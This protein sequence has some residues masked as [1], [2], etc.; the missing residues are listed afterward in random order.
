MKKIY[1]VSTGSYS[2]Y[3]VVALFTTVELAEEFMDAVPHSDYNAVEE[4][5]L[6]PDTPDLVKRGYSLWK[7]Q[8]LRNGDTEEAISLGTSIHYMNDVGH[9]VWRRT[10]VPTYKKNGV[11]D[12]LVSTVWAKDKNA[13][14]KI[15]NE[16]RVQLIANG[17]W[18]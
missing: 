15:V 17:E 2:D 1:A 9:W 6:N 5:T 4:F 7:V 18:D 13:A 16:H 14:I 8:M 12:C 3:T 11:P 10:N